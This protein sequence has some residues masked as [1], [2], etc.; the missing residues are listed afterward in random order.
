M[1]GKSNLGDTASESI[2][3]AVSE[4]QYMQKNVLKKAESKLSNN[5]EGA[6]AGA[7]DVEKALKPFKGCGL[8]VELLSP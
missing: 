3:G 7:Y 4:E 5:F 6:L 8:L 1:S 2:Q